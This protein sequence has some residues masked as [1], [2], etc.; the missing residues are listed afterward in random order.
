MN[1]HD[2]SPVETFCR[3]YYS[4]NIAQGATAIDEAERHR[5][6]TPGNN[7]QIEV[8]PMIVRRITPKSARKWSAQAVEKWLRRSAST[9]GDN[10]SWW[11]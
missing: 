6:I 2:R 10:P 1:G 11:T 3:V 4:G 9:A 7:M 8:W 5:R